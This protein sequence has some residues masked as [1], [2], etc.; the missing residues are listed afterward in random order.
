MPN[1]TLSWKDIIETQLNE[2]D[3]PFCEYLSDIKNEYQND[4]CFK[5]HVDQLSKKYAEK[6]LVNYGPEKDENFYNRCL[7]AA[8]DYLLE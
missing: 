2:E 8:R 6:L 3:K 5:G 4:K 1:E 7:K